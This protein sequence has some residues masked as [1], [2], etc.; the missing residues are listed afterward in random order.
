ML[1]KLFKEVI[2]NIFMSILRVDKI[3]LVGVILSLIYWIWYNFISPTPQIFYYV[4]WIVVFGLFFYLCKDRI[5]TYFKSI[6]VSYFYKFLIIGLLI[7]L[8]EEIFAALFN[9]L[10]EGFNFSLYLVRILQFWLLNIIIFSVWFIVW[11]QLLSR[12]RY[13]QREVF[14]LAGITGLFMEGIIYS[15]FSNPLYFILMLLPMIYVYGIIISVPFWSIMD[16]NKSKKFVKNRI[17]LYI[18]SIIIILI[19]VYLTGIIVELLKVQY[20]SLFPPKFD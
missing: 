13:S 4:L 12:Y 5:K 1:G 17:L 7:I 15:I 9:H 20:P 14:W 2:I 8:L 16:M 11:Y 10:S 19:F 18:L 3:F 6:K